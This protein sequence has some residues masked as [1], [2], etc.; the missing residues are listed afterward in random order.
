MTLVQSVM[1]KFLGYGNETCAKCGLTFTLAKVDN[2]VMQIRYS[3][4]KREKNHKPDMT[5]E[6]VVTPGLLTLTCSCGYS[7]QRKGL[8][9]ADA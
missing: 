6:I 9:A 5:T 1:P 2:G 3:G 8:D 7:S 4:E